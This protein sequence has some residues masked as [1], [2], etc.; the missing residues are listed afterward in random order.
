MTEIAVATAVETAGPN[1]LYDSLPQTSQDCW[2]RIGSFG[3]RPDKDDNGE[4]V[5]LETQ[6][7]TIIGPCKS[8]S[9]LGAKVEAL[10]LVAGEQ[11]D[12]TTEGTEGTETGKTLADYA[13][14]S[15]DIE[16]QATDDDAAVVE[17]DVDHK[18]NTYLPG[19]KPVVDV[20]LAKAAGD[21]FAANT[22]WSDA[23]KVRTEKKSALD[24]IVGMKRDLFTQDPD[25]TNSLI[26]HAGGLK[27]RI[28]KESKT[29]VTVEEESDDA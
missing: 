12:L 4:W 21:F 20:Q 14:A 25:N 7:D 18:G 1:E 13:H 17:I 15:D 10:G 16:N 19:V 28:A 29:K 6:G 24:T 23:G 3:F 26:Y 27:I 8:L 22:E 11:E 9:E 2:D 5:A